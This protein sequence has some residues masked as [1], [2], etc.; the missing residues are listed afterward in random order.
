MD[1]I[2]SRP[3]P[4]RDDD[5]V[6]PLDQRN[7]EEDCNDFPLKPKGMHWRTYERLAERYEAY[8]NQWSLDAIRR[9]GIKL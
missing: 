4:P 8:D 2:K 6:I 5:L 9:F 7:P 3:A 1:P